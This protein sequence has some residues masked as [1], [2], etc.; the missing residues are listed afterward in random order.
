MTINFGY[1]FIA[2]K[3]VNNLKTNVDITAVVEA[4]QSWSKSFQLL[5]TSKSG[6]IAVNFPVDIS[7]YSLLGFNTPPLAANSI[8]G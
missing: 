3:P 1:Q 5:S 7:S 6:N 2:D 8:V 4:P